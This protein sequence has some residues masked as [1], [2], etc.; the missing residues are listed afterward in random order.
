MKHTKK[1]KQPKAKIYIEFNGST[2]RVG[3]SARCASKRD[4]DLFRRGVCDTEDG[5]SGPLPC[6]A[7]GDAFIAICGT[8]PKYGFK[9]VASTSKS[10]EKGK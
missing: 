5:W 9:E 3:S 2:Y 10:T 7:I 1:Q 4:C 8:C 6:E